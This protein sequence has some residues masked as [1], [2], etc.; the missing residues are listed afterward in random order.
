[1]YKAMREPQEVEL[2]KASF[3]L[4]F[5]YVFVY[6]YGWYLHMV[7]S[8]I[9]GMF[10]KNIQKDQQEPYICQKKVVILQTK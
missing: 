5:V 2:A 9:Q 3:T 6:S 8:D 10:H 4:F 1:M 7:F